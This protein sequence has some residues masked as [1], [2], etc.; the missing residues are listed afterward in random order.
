MSAKNSLRQWL[1]LEQLPG[2]GSKCMANLLERTDHNL[3]S[4]FD[5]DDAR[6]RDMGLSA[7]QIQSLRHP[8]T[9]WID[10]ALHWQKSEPHHFLLTLDHPDYPDRLR[11]IARPPLILFAKGDPT[12]LNLLQIAIVG[13]RNPSPAGRDT[14]HNL[15]K[16]LTERGIVVTSGLA[17]GIDGWA[18]RGA[19]A[20]KGRTIAVLGTGLDHIYP[21]RHV[22]LA[23]EIITQGGC[24]LSEFAPPVGALPEHFPRRNRL[25]S[26]LSVGTLVVEAALRSGSL[27]TA[28]YALEQGREVFAVPGSI[29]NPL[30]KGCHHLI[31]QGAI[32][33]EK[34]EDILDEFQE[35]ASES[36]SIHGPGEE[37]SA[38]NCL[39]KDPLLDS[40][41][42]EVTSIDVIAQ[43]SGMPVTQVLA[44]LLEYEL[45]GLVTAVPGGYVKL[46]GK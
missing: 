1:A 35:F 45:R 44:Q 31:R 32:L 23:D 15:A 33:V 29:N 46:G 4:L 12:V 36:Q 16:A 13:S 22:D 28:R 17:L 14:A 43:R 42:F 30:A 41:E 37:K 19:L 34:V 18:H 3:V 2:L 10:A 40:V 39:A 24:L 21:R 9:D 25:I 20:A 6:L 38:G 5:M 7:T 8:N 27:I 11:Q 26:G